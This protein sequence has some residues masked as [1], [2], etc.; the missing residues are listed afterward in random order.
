MQDNI[1]NPCMDSMKPMNGM[2]MMGC[3]PGMGYMP[4]MPNINIE[5]FDEEEM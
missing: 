3:M 1:P 5:E 2:P 4:G